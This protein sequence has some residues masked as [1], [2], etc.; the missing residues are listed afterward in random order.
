[1]T[2]AVGGMPVAV[3]EAVVD[4]APFPVDA[5]ALVAVVLDGIE[6]VLVTPPGPAVEVAAPKPPAPSI[7]PSSMPRSHANALAQSHVVATIA[8]ERTSGIYTMPR[9]RL[10]SATRG[11]RL[12]THPGLGTTFPG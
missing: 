12:T 2:C 8:A 7:W 11:A 10:Q 3:V 5:E 6:P 4:D 1:M 9:R